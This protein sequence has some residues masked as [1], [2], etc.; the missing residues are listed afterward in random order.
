M[1]NGEPYLGVLT[2]IP[3]RGTWCFTSIGIGGVLVGL[4]QH[5]Y[6]FSL[7]TVTRKVKMRAKPIGTI[8]ISTLILF[9]T[10][11][12]VH[13]AIAFL[14]GVHPFFF[15]LFDVQC[16]GKEIASIVGPIGLL[17]SG[18]L[19]LTKVST[20]K[21]RFFIRC[22]T[23]WLLLALISSLSGGIP[24]RIGAIVALCIAGPAQVITESRELMENCADSPCG[25]VE[26]FPTA[27]GRVHPGVVYATDELVTIKKYGLGDFAGFVVYPEDQSEK[28]YGIRLYDTLYWVDPMVE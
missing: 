17:V 28:R 24:S 20:F 19:A 2:L 26:D 25:L 10:I 4:W 6:R 16:I 1:P 27:I 5:N 21:T 7:V 3:T 22:T 14:L 12:A 13:T 9:S 11:V 15:W 18:F 23:I 8:T